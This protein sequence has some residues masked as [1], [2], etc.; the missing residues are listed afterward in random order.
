MLSSG[1][2]DKLGIAATSSQRKEE[3]HAGDYIRGSGR[4]NSMKFGVT[5]ETPNKTHIIQKVLAV[6]TGEE[7]NYFEEDERLPRREKLRLAKI[8]MEILPNCAFYILTEDSAKSTIRIP[9]NVVIRQSRNRLSTKA[10]PMVAYQ[11]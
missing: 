10:G 5:R 8:I 1:A 7:L 3:Q 9:K 4:D 6:S 2:S 11:R